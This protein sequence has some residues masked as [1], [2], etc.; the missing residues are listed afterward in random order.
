MSAV[1]YNFHNI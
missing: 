1:W